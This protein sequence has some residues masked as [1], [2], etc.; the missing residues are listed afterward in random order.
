MAN[1]ELKKLLIQGYA[2]PECTKELQDSIEAFINPE[3]YS[4]SFS[5]RYNPSEETGAN[6]VTQRF[7]GIATSGFELDLVVDGTGVAGAIEGGTV[8]G[9]IDK[10]KAVVYKYVGKE[11]KPNYIKITW[12]TQIFIGICDKLTLKYTLFNPDGTPLR[13]SVKMSLRESVDYA[14][15]AKE[16]KKSSP[17][18]THVRTVKAGDNLP[19]MTYQIYGDSSYYLEV[20]RA[21]NLKSVLSIKPGDQLYFP[22][23]K[24]Q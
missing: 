10:L 4:R 13:A 9:Y 23:I 12:G 22:P 17:D 6:G 1:G 2:D 16:A 21:N 18:L 14:T 15:K 5:V 3:T 19:L 8:N 11:H 20:A 7:A 24:K